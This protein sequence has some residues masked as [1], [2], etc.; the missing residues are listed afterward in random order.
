MATTSNL[1]STAK[2]AGAMQ[3]WTINAAS[4]L[5]A[6][7]AAMLAP[8]L[9]KIAQSFQADPHVAVGVS[10]VAT[11]PAL[12]IAICAFPAGLLADR[13]GTRRVFLLGVGVYGFLG[14]APML[15]DSL[16]SVLVTRALLGI[17]GAIIM[18]CSAALLAE[19]FQGDERD[20]WFAINTA[21]AGL[22]AMVA[23]VLGGMLGQ[24]NWRFA[25][26]L[27]GAAFILF[28]ILLLKT[29]SPA[30]QDGM[31][32]ANS[33]QAGSSAEKYHWGPVALICL[34]TVFASMA[35]YVVIIQLSFILSERGVTSPGTIGLAAAIAVL[36]MALG[37]VLFKLLPLPVAGKLATSFAFSAIGFLVLA[38]SHGFVFT[39]VGAAINGIGSG[40]AL[41]TLITWAIS[42]LTPAV[43]ASGTGIWQASFFLGQFFSPLTILLLKNAMGSLGNAVLVYAIACAIAAAIA[44]SVSFR[45]GSQPRIETASPASR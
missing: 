6:I 40:M 8:V 9:P 26:A 1:L 27:N 18:T 28:P 42:K 33:N 2:T 7:A 12:F 36:F 13:F 39:E 23:V 34:I 11:L 24:F 4:W 15:L 10:L 37:S 31:R 14:C 22:A 19:Y 5:A 17:A 25:F 20:R 21:G 3:G 29:W 30:A 32:V 44:L 38:L 35:F 16:M 43:R 45:S 41:P